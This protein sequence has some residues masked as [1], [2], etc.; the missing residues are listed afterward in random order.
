MVRRQ[1][2]YRSK[3]GRYGKMGRVK[4]KVK[5]KLAVTNPI[6]AFSIEKPP[7]ELHG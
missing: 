2:R 6:R 3:D 1:S 4:C 7:L 5:S